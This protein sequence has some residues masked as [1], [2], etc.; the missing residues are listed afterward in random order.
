MGYI[1]LRLRSTKLADP[2][3][4]KA[5]EKRETRDARAKS[6]LQVQNHYITTPPPFFCYSIY[7]FDPLFYL[8][9]FCLS[10]LAFSLS[11]LGRHSLSGFPVHCPRDGIWE[12]ASR[13]RFGSHSHSAPRA[14]GSS[15]SILAHSSTFSFPGTPLCAGHHLISMVM[16]GLALR[17]AAMCFLAWSAHTWPGPGSSEASRLMAACASVTF[18]PLFS[19]GNIE[20][21]S[22]LHRCSRLQ[23]R[24]VKVFTTSP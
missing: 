23:G 11:R 17:G 14:S 16:S 6:S 2:H 3:P 22:I 10:I 9:I 21:V 13:V 8:F 18:D 1:A 12:A 5:P 24:Y 15:A 4:C 20:Y 19:L 7:A